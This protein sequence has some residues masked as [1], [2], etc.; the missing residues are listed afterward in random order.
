LHGALHNL[1]DGEVVDRLT[2]IVRRGE[3]TQRGAYHHVDTKAVAHLLLKVVATMVGTK[4]Y[5]VKAYGI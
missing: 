2:H 4:I 3:V 1:I 5:A